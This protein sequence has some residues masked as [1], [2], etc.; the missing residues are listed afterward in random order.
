[1]KDTVRLLSDKEFATKLLERVRQGVPCLYYLEL[2]HSHLRFSRN[3]P[4]S[5]G[6]TRQELESLRVRIIQAQALAWMN[7]LRKLHILGADIKE[8]EEYYFEVKKILNDKQL[9]FQEL[10][11]VGIS[12]KELERFRFYF[13]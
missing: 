10:Y 9:S 3:S 13:L 12:R 6:S 4:T 1:M 5:I 8:Q 7:K 11:A 2:I